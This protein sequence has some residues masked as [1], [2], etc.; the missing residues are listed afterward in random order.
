M[1]STN[2]KAIVHMKSR[3][4]DIRVGTIL[5]TLMCCG[6]QNVHMRA[7]RFRELRSPNHSRDE[8]EL[9]NYLM[10]S[11]K[12]PCLLLAG[13]LSISMVLAG[14][15][16]FLA[17]LLQAAGECGVPPLQEASTRC[18]IGIVLFLS[19]CVLGLAALGLIIQG[20]Q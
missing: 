2:E 1:A 4:G 5:A 8:F 13:I 11:R 20:H 12:K 19:G 17:N 10:A 3:Y 16:L 6:L 9:E 14:V 18:S 7:I 15:W